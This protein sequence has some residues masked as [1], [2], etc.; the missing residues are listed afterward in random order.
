MKDNVLNNCCFN[1]FYQK[2]KEKIKSIQMI[3]LLV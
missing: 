1:A 2:F 3:E